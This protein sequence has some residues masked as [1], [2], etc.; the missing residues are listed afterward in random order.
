MKM[1]FL[2]AM[3]SHGQQCLLSAV[4]PRGILGLLTIFICNRLVR[5]W[6][7]GFIWE[8]LVKS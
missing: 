8:K 3:Q 6:R 5:V 4:L 1:D 2:L 7:I